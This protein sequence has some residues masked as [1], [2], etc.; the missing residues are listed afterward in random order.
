MTMSRL[1]VS[2]LCFVMSSSSCSDKV[3][4]DRLSG[5]RPSPENMPLETH[6]KQSDKIATPYD[7]VEIWDVP[8]IVPFDEKQKTYVIDLIYAVR[9]VIEGSSNLEVEERIILGEGKFFWPKN[10]SEPVMVERYYLSDRFRMSGISLS[11]R[12][13][14]R[15]TPWVSAH[16][17]VYPRNFP[18]GVYNMQLPPGIFE[19]FKLEKVIREER[20]EERIASPIVFYF[21]SKKKDG[22]NLIVECRDDL[23]GIQDAFPASFHLIRIMRAIKR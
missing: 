2:T 18:K 17:A 10:P 5:T 23:V 12:R 4:S 16:L 3:I 20:P 6:M 13:A 15:G 19:D 9:R 8:R 14:D 22:V 7:D 1:I 21:K 11:L